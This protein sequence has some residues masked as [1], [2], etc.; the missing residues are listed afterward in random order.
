[1]GI[2]IPRFS[3]VDKHRVK[4]LKERMLVNDVG[5]SGVEERV[6]MMMRG[7]KVGPKSRSNALD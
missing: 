7:A 6:S 1:M 3:T 2:P 5:Q 4:Y